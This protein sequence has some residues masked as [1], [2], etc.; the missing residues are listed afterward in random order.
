MKTTTR[1][2]SRTARKPSRLDI[3]SEGLATETAA[4]NEALDA[5]AV[6]TFPTKEE[7]RNIG[8]NAAG[9][10]VVRARYGLD[11]LWVTTAGYGGS[12]MFGNDDA[13]GRLLRLAGVPRDP[14]A[15]GQF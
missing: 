12:F 1:K 3:I 8:A 13:W 14:R 10:R 15:L 2:T 11:G 4:L 6:V 9:K 7:D 5:G